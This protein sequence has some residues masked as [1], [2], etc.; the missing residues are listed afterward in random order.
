MSRGQSTVSETIDVS[1]YTIPTDR[2]ESDGTYDW[3]ETTL[4][5]VQASAGGKR[6]LGYS[7]ADMATGRLISDLL[8][9]VIRGR[10]AMDIPGAWTGMVRAIRNLGRPG[11]CSMTIS[12][13]DDHVRI[14]SM[15]FDGLPELLDGELH[16]DLSRPG[17]GLE[18]KAADARRYRV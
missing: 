17:M 10:D 9:G 15:L 16:P 8:A 2:A 4:V 3:K 6:G 14:E 12:A 13:V 7:Y 5:L 1:A 18:L 11:I